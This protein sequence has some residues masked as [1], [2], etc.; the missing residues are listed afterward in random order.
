MGLG[1]Y[2]APVF[3]PTV[4]SHNVEDHFLGVISTLKTIDGRA[5]SVRLLCAVLH[6]FLATVLMDN[7]SL[8]VLTSVFWLALPTPPRAVVLEAVPRGGPAMDYED[9]ET[10]KMKETVDLVQDRLPKSY[11]TAAPKTVEIQRAIRL[12]RF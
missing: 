2:V 9:F 4:I 1:A 11:F 12:R 3:W 7:P 5:E 8:A 6:A 10:I